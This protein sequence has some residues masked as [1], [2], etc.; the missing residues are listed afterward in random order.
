LKSTF[1]SLCSAIRIV[2][3]VSPL[4]FLCAARRVSLAR[5]VA[6][7]LLGTAALCAQSQTATTTAL[8]LTSAGESVSTVP[9]G[10]VITLTATVLGG[11]TPIEPGIVN[12]CDASVN[13]C[14]DVHL[15][16]SKHLLQ[17]GAGIGTATVKF[18]PGPGAHSYKAVFAGT[19][20]YSASTSTVSDV[21]VTLGQQPSTSTLALTGA[22]GN[23]TLTAT[24]SGRGPTPPSGTVTFPDKQNSNVP[25]G[26][27]TLST[28][29]MGLSWSIAQNPSQTGQMLVGDFNADG[30]SDIAFFNSSTLKMT[31]LEGHGDGTFTP[32]STTTT[33]TADRT[34]DWSAI[35]MEMGRQI[36]QF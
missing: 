16:A 26:T 22:A 12:F 30:I 1:S 2:A 11:A 19:H 35:S 21:T 27:A 36:S 3:L 34:M 33:L 5:T 8:A 17:S 18:V 7:L 13:Y 4:R 31:I 9:A 32:L 23:Y 29:D 10:T 14:T 6:W 24:V 15:I 20:Y 25:V 28:G